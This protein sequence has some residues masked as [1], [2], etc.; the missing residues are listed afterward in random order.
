MQNIKIYNTPKGS[1]FLSGRQEC[2]ISKDDPFTLV[3]RMKDIWSQ[4]LFY[5]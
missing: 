1:A 4:N 5:V 3:Y 2:C